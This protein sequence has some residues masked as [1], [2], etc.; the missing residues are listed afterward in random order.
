MAAIRAAD[1]GFG[2]AA[3]AGDAAALTAFYATMPS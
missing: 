2:K 1:K 3:A